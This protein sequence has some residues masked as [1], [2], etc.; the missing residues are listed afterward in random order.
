MPVRMVDF[1]EFVESLFRIL[2]AFLLVKD[3]IRRGGGMGRCDFGPA[4]LL[5]MRTLSFIAIINC[6]IWLTTLFCR[7]SYRVTWWRHRFRG[8]RMERVDTAT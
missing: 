3:L 7:T 6:G 2:R 8:Q 1:D 5:F 4:E